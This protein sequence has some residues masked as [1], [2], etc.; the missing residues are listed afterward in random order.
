[1][2]QVGFEPTTSAW[3]QHQLSRAALYYFISKGANN[4][5][6]KRRKRKTIAGGGKAARESFILSINK[7]MTAGI[8][9]TLN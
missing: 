5:S 1:V 7:N 8:T 6:G 4:R 2:D 9:T 3:Q